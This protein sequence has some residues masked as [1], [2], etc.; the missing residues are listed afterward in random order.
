MSPLI[1]SA[2]IPTVYQ[3]EARGGPKG[4]GDELLS[5]GS[6]R[7]LVHTYGTYCPRHRAGKSSFDPS[8][9]AVGSPFLAAVV[10]RDIVFGPHG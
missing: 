4:Y 6:R 2:R 8:S 3:V 5:S 7:Y 10:N 1:S 9:S